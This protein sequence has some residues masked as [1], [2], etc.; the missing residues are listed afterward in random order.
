MCF[1][2]RITMM[3]IAINCIVDSI[4]NYL[5]NIDLFDFTVII[6]IIKAK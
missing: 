1:N 2:L 4:A 6:F 3:F 5:K